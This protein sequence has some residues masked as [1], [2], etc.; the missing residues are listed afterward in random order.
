MEFVDMLDLIRSTL[1]NLHSN[2]ITVEDAEKVLSDTISVMF[3]TTENDEPKKEFSVKFVEP[4]EAGDMFIVRTYPTIYD[5]CQ[6]FDFCKDLCMHKSRQELFRKWL[7]NH[8]WNVEI[9]LGCVKRSLYQYEG[10]LNISPEGLTAILVLD[11]LNV[12]KS[13]SVINTIYDAYCDS[14]ITDTN[15]DVRRDGADVGALSKLYLIPILEA[16]FIKD[17][18]IMMNPV[19]ISDSLEITVSGLDDKVPP[20]YIDAYKCALAQLIKNNGNTPLMK[21]PEEKF[22]KVCERM[23]WA[24][25]YYRDYVKRRSYLRDELTAYAMRTTSPT[26]RVIYLSFLDKMGMEL[27]ER[28]TGA[29]VEGLIC[30]NHD[31]F[32]DKN[33]MM[34]Y[35]IERNYKKNSQFDM[36]AARYTQAMESFKTRLGN[37]R[38][39]PQLPSEK[40]IDLIFVDIDRMSDQ[41]ARKVVLNNIYDLIDRITAFEE[42]YAD[43]ESVMRR[44][45]P[46]INIMLDRLNEARVEVLNKR[47][48]KDNYKVFV[49]SP[50]GYEG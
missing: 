23:L 46:V 6:T 7:A 47:S 31:L 48:F 44:W 34:N 15:F 8:I 45:S 13:E 49:N 22:Q 10:N 25:R 35:S 21:T 33:V 1:D 26:L 11:V 39:R 3:G 5:D 14:Y 43:D 20:E 17:W 40:E 19:K 18:I 36:A 24:S 16:C 29:V 28:Y 27:H 41:Y 32:T 30:D 2:K 37:M 4:S 38:V 12:A 9:N 42:F 50:E